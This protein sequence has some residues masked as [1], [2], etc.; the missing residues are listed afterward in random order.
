LLNRGKGVQSVVLNDDSIA[1]TGIKPSKRVI[2]HIE[3]YSMLS[4]ID[5][6]F[7]R[8]VKDGGETAMSLESQDLE[9]LLKINDYLDAMNMIE[10]DM[11]KQAERQRK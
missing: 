11:N 1:S 4:P 7:M 10:S 2:A 8:A 5:M 3:K 9:Y 6:L